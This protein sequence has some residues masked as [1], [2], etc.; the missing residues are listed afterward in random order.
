MLQKVFKSFSDGI[1]QRAKRAQTNSCRL[2]RGS[3]QCTQFWDGGGFRSL[4]CKP[5]GGWVRSIAL[6]SQRSE[7][8]L[9][10]CSRSHR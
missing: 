2:R 9:V 1:Q 10:S 8:G 3:S 5:H 4:A 7:V 6:I